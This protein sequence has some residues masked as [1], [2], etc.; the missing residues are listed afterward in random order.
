MENSDKTDVAILKMNMLNNWLICITFTTFI[1]YISY[2]SKHFIELP[3][4]NFI[5]KKWGEQKTYS[6]SVWAEK[7]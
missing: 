3:T 2:L 1:L 7:N 6:V 5:D 4:R